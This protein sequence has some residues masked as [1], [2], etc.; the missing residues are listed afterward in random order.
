MENNQVSLDTFGDT[1]REE[2]AIDSIPTNPVNTAALTVGARQAGQGIIQYGEPFK[3]IE[4]ATIGDYYKYETAVGNIAQGLLTGAINITTRDDPE[5]LENIENIKKTLP[6]DLPKNEIDYV[7][8]SGSQEEWDKRLGIAIE[9]SAAYR[10]MSEDSLAGSLRKSVAAVVFD[11]TSWFLGAGYVAVSK[12]LQLSTKGRVM[13]AAL[14]GGLYETPGLAFNPNKG[15]VDV[16]VGALF[17]GSF[18]LMGEGI[19]STLARRKLNSQLDILKTTANE[20]PTTDSVGAARV[21]GTQ[22]E[23]DFSSQT[24]VDDIAVKVDSLTLDPETGAPVKKLGKIEEAIKNLDITYNGIFHRFGA[25]GSTIANWFSK[26]ILSDATGI[27]TYGITASDI[28]TNLDYEYGSGLLDIKSLQ[29]AWVERQSNG[30]I[31]TKTPE[32]V[33]VGS[34]R[35]FDEAVSQYMLRL[36]RL[37]LDGT[38]TPEAIRKLDLEFDE[39]VVAAGARYNQMY[40]KI[41]SDLKEAGVYGFGNITHT[42]GYF[43]RIIDRTKFENNIKYHSYYEQLYGQNFAKIAKANHN[44]RIEEQQEV[45]NSLAEQR[46]KFLYE[47]KTAEDISK[48]DAKILEQQQIIDKLKARVF[49]DEKYLKQGKQFFNKIATNQLGFSTDFATIAKT[50]DLDQLEE[51]LGDKQLAKELYEDFK[52]MLANQAKSSRAK[53]RF[54]FDLNS[55]ITARD[56]T[57]V[58]LKDLYSNDMGGIYTSYYKEMAGRNALAQKGIKSVDSDMKELSLQAQQEIRTTGDTQALADAIDDI[59]NLFLNRPIKDAAG[60]LSRRAGELTEIAL[61][62]KTGVAQLADYSMIAGNVGAVNT[63][64]AMPSFRWLL[65]N[66]TKGE[67]KSLLSE[68]ETLI[69]SVGND[70]IIYNVYQQRIGQTNEGSLGAMGRNVDHALAWMRHHTYNLNLMNPITAIQQKAAAISATRYIV[71]GAMR[72][73]SGTKRLL[74]MGVDKDLIKGIR[75]EVENGNIV[76][77]DGTVIALNSHT[78][79]SKRIQ[80]KFGA[81]LRRTVEQGVQKTSIGETAPFMHK[82]IGNWLFKL[83]S[84]AITATYKQLGRNLHL[85]DSQ[86]ATTALYA[87]LLSAGV[88]GINDAVNNSAKEDYF[89]SEEHLARIL[90]GSVGYNPMLGWLPEGLNMAGALNLVP[91]E[92]TPRGALFGREG[93]AALYN[94]DFMENIVNFSATAGGINNIAAFPTYLLSK[95]VQGELDDIEQEEFFKYMQRSMWMGNS[96]WLAPIFNELKEE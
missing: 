77:K 90:V 28:K 72:G 16:A 36:E 95:A 52:E 79:N 48:L 56:G 41:L 17:G 13:L 57:V 65:S 24:L 29:S 5:F 4:N 26:D 94:Q 39:E 67:D 49:D 31:F 69:G 61:L 50:M 59:K 22:I 74:A 80:A 63:L 40:S 76:Y 11:P 38:P 91:P 3:R 58:S 20:T 87:T 9:R 46:A 1:T 27:N 81:A 10:R 54:D 18:S 66:A 7:M 93:S 92:Y 83:Q 19:S 51:I 60:T 25:K 35:E 53:S 70:P 23:V 68:I 75:R 82:D 73:E 42:P 89:G 6:E 86:S 62:D 32:I 84:F 34:H 37:Y 64:K 55:S 8:K 12:S 2:L 43:P 44:V 78:W 45:L 21:E 88:Y 85:R 30:S 96:I 33:R 15:S 71:D 47:G 14:E